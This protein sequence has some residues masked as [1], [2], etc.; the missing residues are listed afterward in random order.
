MS[1]KH[2]LRVIDAPF[3]IV[4]GSVGAVLVAI[5]LGAVGLVAQEQMDR[6]AERDATLRT[7]RVAVAHC[8][9]AEGRG[10]HAACVREQLHTPAVFDPRVTTIAVRADGREYAAVDASTLR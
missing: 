9:G 1:F 3:A 4:V 5:Q 10:G 7:Q 8:L 6:A 2:Y